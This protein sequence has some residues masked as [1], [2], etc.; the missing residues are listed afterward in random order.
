MNVL[1]NKYL[2]PIFYLMILIGRFNHT[3]KKD[4]L[5]ENTCIE[6]GRAQESKRECVSTLRKNIPSANIFRDHPFPG[7]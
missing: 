6:R 3:T 7:S 2:K 4:V 1:E 5:E